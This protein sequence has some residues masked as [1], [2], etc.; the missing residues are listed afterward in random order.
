MIDIDE[1]STPFWC[2]TWLWPELK[3]LGY[4][5]K[6]NGGTTSQICRSISE[7]KQI[8]DENNVPY[9]EIEEHRDDE[10]YLYNY[11]KED[12]IGFATKKINEV[13]KHYD[14][15]IEDVVRGLR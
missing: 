5:S 9:H 2:V 7:A 4:T 1:P 13:L 6:E 15:T 10:I 11:T 8:A 12:M 3:A 14:L